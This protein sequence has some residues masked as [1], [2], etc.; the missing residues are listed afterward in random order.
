MSTIRLGPSIGR[1]AKQKAE[2]YVLI[3]EI[4]KEMFEELGFEKTTL[5]KVADKAGISPGAIFKHFEN[6]AAL[7]AA[8]LFA[9]IEAVQEKALNSIPQN[10]TLQKQFLFVAGEFF[11]YYAARPALSK[12]LVKHSLFIEGDWARKFN[13]QTF[14]LIEKTGHLIQEAKNQGRI[15]SEVD[16]QVLASAFYSHYLLVL[17]LS[18]KE[19]A[20]D[21]NDALGKLETLINQT[22]SGAMG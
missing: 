18:V 22:L 1:R 11:K 10:E 3:L 7:L 13:A 20:I 2:T 5:R 8:A 6:K 16:N 14:R 21:P 17:V 19:T 15:R 9:D 12:I 4:A